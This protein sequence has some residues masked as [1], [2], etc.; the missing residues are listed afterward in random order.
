MYKITGYMRV[1]YSDMSHAD[2]D[3]ISD[4]LR[5]EMNIISK[6]APTDDTHLRVAVEMAPKLRN[7]LKCQH[8]PAC[9]AD[10]DLL[11]RVIN[12]YNRMLTHGKHGMSRVYAGSNYVLRVSF[13]TKVCEIPD[14]RAVPVLT[15]N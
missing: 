3:I 7:M 14:A 2:R 5:T 12:D 13:S 6:Q 8:E 9:Q 1:T 15:C 10:F 11:A 4:V